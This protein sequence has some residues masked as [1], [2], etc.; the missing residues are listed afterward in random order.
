[1]AE[2]TNAQREATMLNEQLQKRQADLEQAQL[3]V[4]DL[5]QIL[6]KK[7]RTALLLSVLEG[8]ERVT[9]LPPSQTGTC[10]FLR[11]ATDN[12]H[13]NI[14]IE[15]PSM[16]EHSDLVSS[17][18][19]I[20]WQNFSYTREVTTNLHAYHTRLCRIKETEHEPSSLLTSRLRLR[21]SKKVQANYLEDALERCC[22][23]ARVKA[24]RKMGYHDTVLSTLPCITNE[25]LS[26]KERINGLRRQDLQK[27][28]D[29][30]I[31]LGF[32]CEHLI[33]SISLFLEQTSHIL[34]SSI[35]EDTPNE[36][37]VV[38]V[39][40]EGLLQRVKERS[41]YLA[42]VDA[43]HTPTQTPEEEA[44]ISIYYENGESAEK[45]AQALLTRKV[46]KAVVGE[47]LVEDINTLMKETRSLVG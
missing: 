35:L 2:F 36:P 32:L 10:C 44:L 8:R 25:D 47:S 43:L 40:V 17:V 33:A 20:R 15:T 14:P 41:S 28:S 22:K 38:M 11:F 31:A 39:A 7:R 9:S 6:Q 45:R 3:H 24:Q 26:N 5:K 12:Q 21:L 37:N 46:E 13:R 19:V 23:I 1:M 30:A 34:R 29:K 16:I 42:T 4:E 27:L 18:N